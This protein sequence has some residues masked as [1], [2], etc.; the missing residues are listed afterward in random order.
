MQKQAGTLYA[1]EHVRIDINTTR[2]IKEVRSDPPG[3]VVVH[4]RE[5]FTP[6]TKYWATEMVEV[7]F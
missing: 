6:P 5:S 2:T 7:V 1:G 3:G 4:W